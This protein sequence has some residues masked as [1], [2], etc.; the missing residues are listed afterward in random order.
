MPATEERTTRDPEHEAEAFL[1][2]LWRHIYQRVRAMLHPHHREH[3]PGGK[4]PLVLDLGQLHN[5]FDAG[6]ADGQPVVWQASTR[7]YIPGSL[8]GVGQAFFEMTGGIVVSTILGPVNLTG[9][10]LTI[11]R[12]YIR[13]D[14]AV[15]G[16][17]TAGGTVCSISYGAGGGTTDNDPLSVSWAD[18]ASL[19]AVV[20]TSGGDGTSLC[21][22]SYF[23]VT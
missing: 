17:V 2:L 4:D 14:G 6:I 3:E 8:G 23:E 15:T 19:A 20:A 18:G 1:T 5:V 10:A 21:V 9:A 22:D 16:S 11:T 12:A 7:H 13:A